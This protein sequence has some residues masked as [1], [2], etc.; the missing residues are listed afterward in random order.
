[1]LFLVANGQETV[2][3]VFG[4]FFASWELTWCAL[5][6]FDFREEV[7]RLLFAAT[8]GDIFFVQKVLDPF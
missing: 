4:Y 2:A 3:W 5:A 7:D 8:K 6:A 1:M